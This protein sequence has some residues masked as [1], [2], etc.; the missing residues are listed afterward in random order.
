MIGEHPQESVDAGYIYNNAFRLLM[1]L[2]RHCSELGT[3]AAAR[4]DGF[5]FIMQKKAISP[6]YRM[7]GIFK[8]HVTFVVTL[9]NRFD[10]PLLR[11]KMVIGVYVEV[12]TV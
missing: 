2:P 9:V 1:D 12:T 5:L 11:H 4:T 8:K 3:F 7:P 6:V 10:S